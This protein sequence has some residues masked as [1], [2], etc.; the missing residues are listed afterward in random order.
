M[1]AIFGY[2]NLDKTPADRGQLKR[3]SEILAHRGPDGTGLFLDGSVAVGHRMLR[4]T[5]ESLREVQPLRGP[6]SH[7]CLSMD[8]RVDNRDE[9]RSAIKSAG[10]QLR[11]NTDAELVLAS[12]ECWGERCPEKILGDFSFALWDGRKRTIFCAR[13]RFGVKPLFYHHRPGTLFAFSTEIKGLLSLRG[14]PAR[15]NEVRIG[16]YLAQLFDDQ[17]ITFYRDI[18]RLPPAHWLR[19]GP[20][21]MTIGRY[22]SLDSLREIRLRSDADYADAFRERFQNS[23]RC[24]LRSAFPAGSL[25]SGGLDSSSIACTAARF[26]KDAGSGPLK[27]F[28]AI[29]DSL[30]QCD[31]RAFIEAVLRKGG[32]DPHYVPADQVS[33][34]TDLERVLWHEDEPFFNPNLFLHWSLYGKAQSTSVRVLLDGF[35]GDTTVSYGAA[36]L[37]ELALAGKWR[38]LMGEIKSISRRVNRPAREIAW[39]RVIKPLLPDPA[40]RLWRTFRPGR[41][42]APLEAVEPG[43]ARRIDLK[44]RTRTALP[45]PGRTERQDHH[46]VLT[47]G[48]MSLCLEVLD[49]AAASFSIEPRYPFF[50]SRLAEFC[51]GLP[52]NQKLRNGWSRMI[53]RRAMDG[54]LPPEI[55]WR[56][57]KSNLS[58]NFEKGL[59]AFE[60]ER[61]DDVILGDSSLIGA[62]VNLPRVRELYQD[63]ARGGG[64]GRAMDVW[65]PLTLGLWLGRK[66]KE[67]RLTE[68]VS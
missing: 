16:E 33:P 50:D 40:R 34:L 64:G 49:R 29:F 10:I 1:S 55:Q 18:S 15:I 60:R 56:P 67:A 53:L 13:D 17:A 54:I 39:Q 31:E 20:E 68:S 8:G 4:S 42:P 48:A 63:Y 24:R 6:R 28:S 44:T 58:A 62:F 2:Y 57:G 27:T 23:V 61:L 5:P 9:L 65:S 51:L 36:F 7:L 30:P 37:T 35:D 59:L 41:Q 3:M 52:P 21:G 66:E 43:F 11:D 22:W 47:W 45:R 12:Y 19:V 25:L 32:F 38:S 14:V 26:L 46:G